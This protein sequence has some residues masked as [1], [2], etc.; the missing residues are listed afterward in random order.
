VAR[1]RAAVAPEIF[2]RKCPHCLKAVPFRASE[3]RAGGKLRVTTVSCTS[4]G[5][6]LGVLPYLGPYPDRR[7]VETLVR[8]IVK[9]HVGA[10][11]KKIGKQIR[12]VRSDRR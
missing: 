4:C 7:E 8:G 1:K 11:A 2:K 3:E 10:A 9:R 6:V 5:V 12:R